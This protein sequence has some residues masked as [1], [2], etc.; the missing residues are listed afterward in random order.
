MML[1]HFFLSFF[2]GFAVTSSTY[3]WAILKSLAALHD[4]QLRSKVDS[5]RRG[6]MEIFD[7]RG[8]LWNE[9]VFLQTLKS[10]KEDGDITLH[11]YTVAELSP[12]LKKK[13]VDFAEHRIE[14]DDPTEERMR[15]F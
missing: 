15:D 6:A 9:G 1:I 7:E 12:S 13:I 8:F 11:S 3:R 2:A 10:M 4:Y 5:I 14:I